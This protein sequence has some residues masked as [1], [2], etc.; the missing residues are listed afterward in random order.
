MPPVTPARPAVKGPIRSLLP[1]DYLP[2]DGKKI[3]LKRR[4][5]FPHYGYDDEEMRK[6][7]AFQNQVKASCASQVNEQIGDELQ[8]PTYANLVTIRGGRVANVRDLVEA[9]WW[10]FSPNVA[11]K[12]WM[13]VYGLFDDPKVM[14]KME[15]N[16]MGINHFGYGIPYKR[17]PKSKKRKSTGFVRGHLLHE[18]NSVRQKFQNKKHESGLRVTLKKSVKRTW[19]EGTK[20]TGRRVKHKFDPAM[21]PGLMEHDH[22]TYVSNLKARRGRK[23]INAKREKIWNKE[24]SGV[25]GEKSGPVKDMDVACIHEVAC[26]L[27]MLYV[28]S[29]VACC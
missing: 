22:D 6:R 24:P 20:A 14:S 11:E 18:I 25:A 23:L 19:Q 16:V 26:D 5:D 7:K 13:A 29:G 4:E 15:A 9:Y 17:S 8:K 3:N 21:A 12:A 28:V 2:L 27:V 10:N 1:R